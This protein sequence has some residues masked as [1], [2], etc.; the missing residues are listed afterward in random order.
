[1][2]SRIA[3]L[4][5]KEA[6]MKNKKKAVWTEALIF[7]VPLMTLYFIFFILPLLEGV[8]YS[9]LDWDGISKTKTFAGFGN[10]IKLFTSDPDYFVSLVFTLKYV[11]LNVIATNVVAFL[12]ALVVN[13][14]LKC[15]KF[16]RTCFF[17]PNVISMLI[18]GYIW[19]FIFNQGFSA[20]YKATG[21]D[22]FNI[23]WLGGGNA[24]VV[25]MVIVAMWQGVGYIMILY[26]SGLH[27]V[28]T[29][30]LEAAAID[31][32]N[33]VQ[34][35]FKVTLPL[36][37]PTIGVNLFMVVSQSFRQFDLNVSLTGGGPGRQT[38]SLALDIYTE[39]YQNN[40]M[41][42]AEAKAVIL[43]LIVI[44]IAMLQLRLTR[45][46]EVEA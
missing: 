34:Q 46:K 14:K 45:S 19:R 44:V 33:K 10:Y 29:S 35:F 16:L 17:I 18:V 38:T 23:S 9:L 30:L 32:A 43:F 12:L 37:I 21:W 39:G 25:A 6:L 26:L 40:R 36:M 5:D 20:I 1:M 31:G 42:Y 15:T 13:S 28:D 8:Y 11:V 3:F 2:L 24:S 7:V 4:K 22:F 27:M 41:G